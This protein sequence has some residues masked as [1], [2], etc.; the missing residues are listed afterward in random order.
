VVSVTTDGFVTNIPEL[1]MKLQSIKVEEEKSLLQEYKHL[2][3]ELSGNPDGIELKHSGP[4]II[5]WTTRGQFS[6]ES[7]I[8]ATTGFQARGFTSEELESLFL[9]TMKSPD[10]EIEYIQ[11]SLRSAL[12]LYRSGGHVTMVYKD[13]IF[14]LH[15]DN[16]REIL[17]PNGLDESEIDTSST[18]FDSKPVVDTLQCASMRSLSKIHKEKVYNRQSSVKSSNTY[19]DKLD[20]AVRNFV[21]G[22]LATPPK[23]N[24]SR[25]GMTYLEIIEFINRYK[26]TKMTVYSISKLKNRKQVFKVVPRTPETLAF[27]CYIKEKYPAFDES[28]FFSVG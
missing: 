6:K 21:K 24:L 5:S 17:E 20:L 7:G 22:L 26:K 18:L 4:G 1:E 12:D 3:L 10:K 19:N 11:T 15:Y 13:Q 8:K 28:N 23:Y 9:E 25:D 2:R 14:R 16:R 27:V